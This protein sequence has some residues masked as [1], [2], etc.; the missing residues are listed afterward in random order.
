M[1]LQALILSI[2]A[3]IWSGV[4]ASVLTLGGVLLANRSSTTRLRIQLQH[5][6]DEKAKQRRAELRKDVYLVAAEELVKANAFLASLPTADFTKLDAASSLQG[7]FAVAAKLQMVSDTKT[8][9]LASQLVGTYGQLLLKVMQLVRP[10]QTARSDAQIA[11]QHYDEAQ[12][13]VKRALTAMTAQNESGKAVPEIFAALE[14]SFEFRQKQSVKYGSEQQAAL[15]KAKSLHLD[16]VSQFIPMV[17]DIG[18][19]TTTLMIEIRHE[20]DIESD[21]AAME[22]ELRAQWQT[23]DESVDL[24]LSSLRTTRSSQTLKPIPAHSIVPSGG[25]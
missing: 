14:R 1:T 18:M 19:K 13:E 16:F 7:F 10:I 12:S 11:K 23:M 20:F 5:E 17:K 3:V 25:S 21:G 8:A 9:V 6:S 22:R 4:I 24:L 2:P 15:D